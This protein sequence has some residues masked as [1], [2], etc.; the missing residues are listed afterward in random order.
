MGEIIPT[1]ILSD[2]K[3]YLLPFTFFF[4][5]RSLSPSSCFMDVSLPPASPVTVP[6]KMLLRVSIVQS[7]FPK[8]EGRVDTRGLE[9]AAHV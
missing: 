2:R 3:V 9:C 7:T 8:E 6:S 1:H 5:K 4:Q